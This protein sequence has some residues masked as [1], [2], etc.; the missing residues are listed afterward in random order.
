MSDTAAAAATGAS[1]KEVSE[2]DRRCLRLPGWLPSLPRL[3]LL[4]PFFPPASGLGTP[5]SARTGSAR[6]CMRDCA[7]A[8]ASTHLAACFFLRC[9]PPPSRLAL[10]CPPSALSAGMQD[11][12]ERARRERGYCPAGL[13]SGPLGGEERDYY[14]IIFIYLFLQP[15]RFWTR[16]SPWKTRGI[17]WQL[18]RAECGGKRFVPF[19]P[20]A[21]GICLLTCPFTCAELSGVHLRVRVK[22]GARRKAR[23]IVFL[24]SFLD[25]CFE[26]MQP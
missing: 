16:S 23:D 7:L 6:L 1:G 22:K 5:A 11:H 9:P 15:R 26:L 2:A 20:P 18:F 8:R 24:T 19:F 10:P 21:N 14:Y 4:F 3:P 13:A 17:R 12:V 25:H